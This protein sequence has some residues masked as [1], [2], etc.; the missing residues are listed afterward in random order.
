MLTFWYW[1]LVRPTKPFFIAAC[2]LWIE[3]NSICLFSIW[4]RILNVDAYSPIKTLWKTQKMIYSKLQISIKYCCIKPMGDVFW[5]PLNVRNIIL[6]FI[7]ATATTAHKAQSTLLN[8]SI[9]Y[10]N[11]V[12]DI[13]ISRCVL[14]MPFGCRI[15]YCIEEK[16]VFGCQLPVAS[17]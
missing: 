16:L 9:H 4:I 5:M 13:Q 7:S 17:Y 15:S 10:Y 8:L 12:C 3:T 2:K 11:F 14:K 6:S 1:Y